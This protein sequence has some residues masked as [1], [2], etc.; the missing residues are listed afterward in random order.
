MRFNGTLW[1]RLCRQK[2]RQALGKVFPAQEVYP[3]NESYGRSAWAISQLHIAMSY[4]FCLE[5]FD[6]KPSSKRLIASIE[7]LS[8]SLNKDKALR[9]ITLYRNKAA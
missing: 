7:A 6:I 3:S 4:Y 9:N 8:E 5:L 2:E 1:M